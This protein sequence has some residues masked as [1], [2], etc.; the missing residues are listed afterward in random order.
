[1]R[2]SDQIGELIA[3]LTKARKAF[4]PVVK[5]SNNPFFKSKYAD[6]NELVEATK[7]ALSDNQ[8]AVL[9][10]PGELS[11]EHKTIKLITFLAHSSGQFVQDELILPISQNPKKD[12]YGKIIRDDNGLPVLQ[13]MDAQ[14]MGSAIT[15]GRRYAYGALLNLAAEDDDGNAAAG[16]RLSE[17]QSSGIKCYDCGKSIQSEIVPSAHGGSPVEY[18]LQ[19]IQKKSLEAFGVTL[20]LRCAVVRTKTAKQP[21]PSAEPDNE[22]I[23]S[24]SVS[25]TCTVSKIEELAKQLRVTVIKTATK[26]GEVLSCFHKSLW[27]ALHASK[28]KL[29]V[30]MVKQSKQGY[31]SIEDVVRI[32]GEKYEHGKSET[33]QK[34][35][36]SLRIAEEAKRAKELGQPNADQ[37]FTP[38]IP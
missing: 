19:D 33:Q 18:S 1:M 28:D 34:L 35:E 8:L 24:G 17:E 26:Q 9:Q 12:G 14:G 29:C 11:R 7:D 22:A 5:A 25:L 38:T 31:W 16:K 23:D 3:A 30:F 27:D 10:F 37:L 4:K 6:L 36:E 21:A 20:C 13:D 32:A 15:Y 2:T